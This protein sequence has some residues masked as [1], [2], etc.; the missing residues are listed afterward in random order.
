MSRARKEAVIRLFIT[1]FILLGGVLLLPYVGNA[2][3]AINWELFGAAYTP[4]LSVSDNTGAPGSQ[5]AF[6]GTG[7][8]PNQLAIVYVDGDMVGGVVTDGNG[9]GSFI[10]D[11]TGVADGDLTVV[12]ETDAN[13]SA[14]K[15]ITIDGIEPVVNPP[16]GFSGPTFGTSG[17]NTFLPLVRR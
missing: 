15:T 11:S 6:T 2:R 12:M 10:I 16:G 5:F 7:Y 1:T 3:A 8:Q 9:T 14:F 17:N 4:D 13:V